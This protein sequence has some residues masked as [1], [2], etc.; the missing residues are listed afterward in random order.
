MNDAQMIIP[1]ITHNPLSASAILFGGA[2]GAVLLYTYVYD[3]GMLTHRVAAV[4]G[5]TSR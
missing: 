2:I 3:Y 4:A 5:Q 1:W